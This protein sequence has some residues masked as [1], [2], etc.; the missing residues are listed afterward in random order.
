M[1]WT[2]LLATLIAFSPGVA[3]FA[4]FALLRGKWIA[5]AWAILLIFTGYASLLLANRSEGMDI[6]GAIGRLVAYQL[7]PAAILGL[8]FR[9]VLVRIRRPSP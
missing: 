9:W 4:A 8:L 6:G 2:K 7:P 3:V 5:L 1:T